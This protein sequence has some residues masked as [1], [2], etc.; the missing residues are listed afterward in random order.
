MPKQMHLTLHIHEMPDDK[1]AAAALLFKLSAPWQTLCKELD[2]A[3]LKHSTSVDERQVR[4]PR[5]PRKP[6][7]DADKPRVAEAA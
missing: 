4:K 2:S 5:S 7:A 3:G 6:K 1:F